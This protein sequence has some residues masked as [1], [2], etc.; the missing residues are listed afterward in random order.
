MS[1]TNIIPY[2]AHAPIVYV[3]YCVTFDTAMAVA[4]GFS[5]LGAVLGVLVATAGAEPVHAPGGS[6]LLHYVPYSLLLF[7][8]F[9]LSLF[10]D[11]S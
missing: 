10:I 7:S 9:L 8:Y 5:G 6:Q 4:M 1:P 11:H 2:L 3:C